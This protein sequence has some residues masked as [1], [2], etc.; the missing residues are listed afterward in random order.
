MAYSHFQHKNNFAIWCAARAVQRGFAKS[1]ILKETLETSGVVEF[2]KDGVARNLSQQEFDERHESWCQSI[3]GFWEKNGVRGASYGRAAKLLAIYLKSM[4]VV[5]DNPNGLADIIHPPIDRIVLQNI[6]KDRGINH[7][8]KKYWKGIN[9]TQLDGPSYRQLIAEFR[10]V[11]EGG[12]FW[13]IE[14]YWVLTDDEKPW[15]AGGRGGAAPLMP[16]VRQENDNASPSE[17]GSL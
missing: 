10:Q 9:W 11:L 16:G 14:K 7:P 15:H 2:V 4:I 3:M 6:S 12:P 17:S 13:L 8:H 5:Q 1:S